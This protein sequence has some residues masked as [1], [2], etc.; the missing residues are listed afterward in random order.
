[1]P[2]PD[3]LGLHYQVAKILDESGIDRKLAKAYGRTA[4]V[5]SDIAPDG[6]RDS[7]RAMNVR[8]LMDI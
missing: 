8:M 3:L 1:M 7:E 2:D 4:R 5:A 6:S